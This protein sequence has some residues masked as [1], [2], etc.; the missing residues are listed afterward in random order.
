MINNSY[1]LVL[2][3]YLAVVAFF[4]GYTLMGDKKEQILKSSTLN[5]IIMAFF[6]IIFFLI[7]YLF[8]N[9]MLLFKKMPEKVPNTYIDTNE[10]IEYIES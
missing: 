8:R 4:A 5:I 6:I 3:I 7:G 2:G 9:M 1:D 10:P